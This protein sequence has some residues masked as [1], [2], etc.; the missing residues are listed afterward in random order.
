MYRKWCGG[1]FLCHDLKELATLVK[2]QHFDAVIGGPSCQAHTKLKAIRSPKFPDLTPLVNSLLESIDYD[3]FLF[4]NV[5][6]IAIPGATTSK[7]NALNFP[8]Y[9]NGQAYH[10]S[11]E[12][13]FTHTPNLKVPTKVVLGGVNELMAYSVVA[14]RIYGPKRG[15]VLQGWPEFA[16]L[17]E[18]CQNLQEALA[19]GVPRGLADAWVRQFQ[20]MW[21]NVPDSKE[22]MRQGA[23]KTH[24][25]RTSNQES[26]VISAIAHAKEN[27]RKITKTY[28]S[29]VAGISRE[30]LSRRYSHLFEKV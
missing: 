11:R 19:D 24:K 23:Y 3:A 21:G 4:E 27:D 15:A 1:E 26:A 6:P 29:S 12:R 7:L 20:L 25:I 13:W 18:S 10:Q 28:I 14:G 5:V 22:R 9:W 30:Q 17:D 2:G 16:S 8:V